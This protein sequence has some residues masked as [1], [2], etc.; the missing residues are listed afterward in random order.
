MIQFIAGYREV[1]SINFA[2]IGIACCIMF[3]M[4]SRR[5]MLMQAHRGMPSVAKCGGTGDHDLPRDF[6]D[7]RVQ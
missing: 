5:L 2:C 7:E 1:L 6:P 4:R 3:P